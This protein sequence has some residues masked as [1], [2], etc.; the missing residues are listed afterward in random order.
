MAR[1][2]KSGSR[3]LLYFMFYIRL[4][5]GRVSAQLSFNFPL[6]TF[7]KFN[8]PNPVLNAASLTELGAKAI[9]ENYL[10]KIQKAQA[11]GTNYRSCAVINGPI[12]LRVKTTVDKTDAHTGNTV[13]YITFVSNLSANTITGPNKAKLLIETDGVTIPADVTDGVDKSRGDITIIKN[14]AQSTLSKQVYDIANFPVS[15]TLTL[16]YHGTIT[17]NVS[18]V[19]TNKTTIAP[20]AGLSDIDSGA[21]VSAVSTSIERDIDLKVVNTVDLSTPQL[22]GTSLNYITTISNAGP[23]EIASPLSATLFIETNGVDIVSDITANMVIDKP[24]TNGNIIVIKNKALSSLNRQV[25]NIVNFPAKGTV[26]FMYRGIIRSKSEPVTNKA[27]I[28]PPINGFYETDNSNNASTV[29]T[30]LIKDIDLQV[31]NSVSPTTARNGGS[32][33]YKTV[34]FNHGMNAVAGSNTITLVIKTEG[35]SIIDDHHDIVADAIVPNGTIVTRNTSNTVPNEQA[36]DIINFP[37]GGTLTLTYK[38]KINS[39][40]TPGI[41]TV[42]VI[43][44]LI[45]FRDTNSDNDMSAVSTTI[46]KD[47]DLQ[48]INTTDVS[49][50]QKIGAVVKYTTTVS[51]LGLNDV[52][53]ALLTIDT[54]G[55][56]IVPNSIISNVSR[57]ELAGVVMIKFDKGLSTLNK[58]VYQ[59]PLLSA[60]ATVTL[61]YQ[62][63]ITSTNHSAINKA[64][65]VPPASGFYDIDYENNMSVAQ[66]FIKP[67]LTQP[68]NMTVCSGQVVNRMLESDNPSFT[69]YT[70]VLVPS[71]EAIHVHPLSVTGGPAIRCVIK[72]EDNDAGM[73]AYIITPVI[74]APIMPIDGGAPV[75]FTTIEG[76]PKVFTVTIKPFTENP[77]VLVTKDIIHYREDA[78]F[79]PSSRLL[80]ATYHWYR[81]PEKNNPVK[82][83]VVDLNGVLTVSNLL[84]GTYTYYVT[85]SNPDFCESAAS[86]VRVTVR[87]AASTKSKSFTPHMPKG[88]R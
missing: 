15:G 86:P 2:I 67:I 50:A 41:N 10:Y 35:V 49:N 39:Q 24:A 54:K 23:D 33:I 20:P 27:M 61:R 73:L 40:S 25:Y 80:S 14:E 77:T 69:S 76:D 21:I 85:V 44:P 26:T 43:A 63:T 58:Y 7:N 11:N 36:Y 17:R 47:V 62:G 68:Q 30:P 18:F 9:E 79:I 51:N 37:S 13:T 42:H 55:V 87:P 56:S 71:S 34:L 78:V 4:W 70:W 74:K 32:V 46:I 66:T 57:N 29:A 38:G 81:D 59:I 48:V 72:N 65:I 31:V 83:G 75:M 5:A 12:D 1:V 45:S 8:G 28:A 6:T 52:T 16:K 88:H 60:G 53:N 3:L 19:A 82:N 64:I 22:A 84:P